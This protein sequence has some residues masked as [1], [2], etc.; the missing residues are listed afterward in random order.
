MGC[1]RAPPAVRDGVSQHGRGRV[2]KWGC[3]GVPRVGV[4]GCPPR[5]GAGVSPAR[6]NQA[7]KRWVAVEPR[8]QSVL[9]LVSTGAVGWACLKRICVVCYSIKRR[10]IGG[11]GGR[12][13]VGFPKYPPDPDRPRPHCGGVVVWLFQ[14]RSMKG[15]GSFR[16]RASEA[17]PSQPNHPSGLIHRGYK[18]T[19]VVLVH[20]QP[21]ETFWSGTCHASCVHIVLGWGNQ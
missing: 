12:G 9:V 6:L 7:V 10:G 15:N 20:Q 14:G 16:T 1:R 4:R 21:G 3:G 2:G 13:L 17:S 18:Q 19:I 8:P 11:G 5:G